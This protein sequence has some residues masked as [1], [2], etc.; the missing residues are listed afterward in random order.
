[1][2][3]TLVIVM[4]G[5]R[6]LCL[7]EKYGLRGF[8]HGILS[9]VRAVRYIFSCCTWM[10]MWERYLGYCRGEFYIPRLICWEAGLLSLGP[11]SWVFL[12]K[13]KTGVF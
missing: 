11:A 2:S 5:P 10:Y 1:M 3:L 8:F 9:W 7:G 13:G 4:G 12:Q 6:R